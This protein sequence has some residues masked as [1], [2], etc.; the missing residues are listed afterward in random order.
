MNTLTIERCRSTNESA[1]Q[2]I[3][4]CEHMQ[5]DQYYTVFEANKQTQ[6]KGSNG[7]TWWSPEDAGIYMS[8]L[9]SFDDRPLALLTTL[10]G[11]KIMCALRAYTY[12]DIQQRGVNDLFLDDRKLGGILCELYKH[13]LI[14]G[15]GLNLFRP[16]KVRKDLQ[17]TAVWLNE[18]SS[19]TLLDRN[20]L[21]KMISEAI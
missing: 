11:Y 5:Q 20:L 8:V 9:Q 15:I 3:D 12:L 4:Q 21:I 2:Y 10:V 18:F 19:E 1:K 17:Q 13:H 14:I 16:T 6:G 7:K